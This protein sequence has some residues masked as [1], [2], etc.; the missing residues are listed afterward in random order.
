MKACLTRA[1]SSS[2][3]TSHAKEIVDCGPRAKYGEQAKYIY[4]TRPHILIQVQWS[5]RLCRK[6]AS[7]QPQVEVSIEYVGVCETSAGHQG[8]LAH[9]S[10]DSG[11]SQGAVVRNAYEK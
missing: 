11:I 7:S 10:S 5:Y 2:F 4:E 6:L 9:T 8:R 3:T 1:L